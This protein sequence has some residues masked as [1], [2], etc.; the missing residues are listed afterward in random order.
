[1]LR[2]AAGEVFAA[3]AMQP[4]DI[5]QALINVLAH[6]PDGP[7]GET[8]VF[9]VTRTPRE[10]SLIAIEAIGPGGVSA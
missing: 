8:W 2:G 4:A 1:M 6:G 5:G 9:G 7:T 10:E 3:K